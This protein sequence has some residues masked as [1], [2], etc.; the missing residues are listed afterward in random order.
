MAWFSCLRVLCA[1]SF[2][3]LKLD[4]PTSNL[5]ELE[6]QALDLHICLWESLGYLSGPCAVQPCGEEFFVFGSPRIS[7]VYD[8]AS[9]KDNRI[10]CIALFPARR[11]RYSSITG[12]RSTL[13]TVPSGCEW[14]LESPL[15]K[16]AK[17]EEPEYWWMNNPTHCRSSSDVGSS[18]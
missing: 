1:W 4:Q 8:R 7:I 5:P 6:S 10:Y 13:Q 11:C 12:S 16:H 9:T 15:L 2:P 14:L 3:S 17:N 18:I